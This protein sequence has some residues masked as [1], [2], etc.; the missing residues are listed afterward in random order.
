MQPLQVD[1]LDPKIRPLVMALR[2]AGFNTCSSCQGGGQ[3]HPG[4]EWRH[5]ERAN[6]WILTDE[7][8]STRIK[9]AKFLSG[10]GI[11]GYDLQEIYSYQKE[12]DPWDQRGPFVAIEFWGTADKLEGAIA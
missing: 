6:V 12:S 7:T 2:D 11:G 10:L 4:T 3:R 1:L 5:W 8:R 9:V